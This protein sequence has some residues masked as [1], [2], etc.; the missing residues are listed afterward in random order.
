[1]ALEEQAVVNREDSP[2]NREDSPAPNAGG[3]SWI[4][5]LA[6]ARLEV[7]SEDELFPITHALSH[8]PT[9]G[10]RAAQPGPQILRLVFASPQTIRRI[11]IHI[12]DRVSERSQEISVHAGSEVSHLVET[13]RQQFNFSPAGS[14]EE[15]EDLRVELKDVTVLELRIDPDRSHETAGSQMYAVLTSFW[16]A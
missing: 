5:V 1:M 13:V 11:W 16:L 14:T 6:L 10:W 4:D 8:S 12:T 9:I 15:I 7:T 2:A 3:G